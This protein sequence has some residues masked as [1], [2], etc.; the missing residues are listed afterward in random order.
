MPKSAIVVGAGIVGLATARALALQ[1]YQVQVFERSP[2]AVGASIRNFGMIWPIGQPAGPL[3]D[4]AMRSRCIWKETMTDAGLWFQEA[5]SLHLAYDAL[6][7]QVMQEFAA[8]EKEH[9]QCQLLNASQTLAQSPA[10]VS[11]GLQGALYCQDELIVDPREAITHLPRYF[12]DQ[13]GI[14]FH[15]N[16]AVTAVSS[17]TVK[18][19]HQHWEADLIFICSGADFETLYPQVYDEQAVTKCKLQMMRI[20]AQPE[21]WRIGPALCG[22]LSMI[23]YKSFA[24]APSLPRLKHYYEAHYADYLQWG[25]HVMVSQNGLGELTIGDSHEYGRHL[26]PFDQSFINEKVLRY[27][28]K[29]AHFKSSRISSSWHGIYAKATDGSTELV[30]QPEESVTIINALGG[31]GMTLSFGLGEEVVAKVM[32]VPRPSAL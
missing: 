11:K 22:G 2:Q 6:E 1:G 26:A 28:Q 4:R 17:H 19:N 21:G 9:R 29:F 16:T 20:E 30:V 8:A 25:I 14:T 18:T 15:W 10:V 12:Q 24:S 32:G 3:L 23:H 31:A 7:W 5:G 27:L 13:F